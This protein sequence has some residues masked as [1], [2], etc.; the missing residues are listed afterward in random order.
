[1]IPP[2]KR[3]RWKSWTTTVS[4]QASGP[5]GLQRLRS[6]PSSGHFRS[7]VWRIEVYKGDKAEKGKFEAGQALT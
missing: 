4:H 3:I 7:E 6:S 2:T 5:L 1:M